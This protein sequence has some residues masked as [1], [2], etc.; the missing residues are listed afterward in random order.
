MLPL[1]PVLGLAAG[2]AFR[3]GEEGVG[4]DGVRVPVSEAG[5]VDPHSGSGLIARLLDGKI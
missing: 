5:E 2:V 1:E 3:E 4:L